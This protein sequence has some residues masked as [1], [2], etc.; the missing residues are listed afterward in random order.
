MFSGVLGNPKGHISRIFTV[1]SAM[2]DKKII[3]QQPNRTCR[4]IVCLLA[5]VFGL[6]VMNV[7]GMAQCTEI[8]AAT[9]VVDF[10]SAKD[11]SWSVSS[12]RT[13]KGCVD[14]NAGNTCVKFIIKLGNYTQIHATK[15]IVK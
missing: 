10:S 4:K 13:E 3:E 11:T 12:K 2:S 7:D 6:V 15:K 1:K 9:Y 8:T 14:G 5:L